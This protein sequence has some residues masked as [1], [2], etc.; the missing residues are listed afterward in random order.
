MKN[1]LLGILI[2]SPL[3]LMACQQKEAVPDGWKKGLYQHSQEWINDEKKDE[4][5]PNQVGNYL[6]IMPPMSKSALIKQVKADMAF[7]K[8]GAFT[9]KTGKKLKVKSFYIA[10]KLTSFWQYY[11]Y[12]NWIHQYHP[13]SDDEDQDT[14]NGLYPAEIKYHQAQNYCAWLAKET[15]LPFALPTFKQWLYAATSRGT[16]W[17]Y[18]TNNGKLELG[19]NYPKGNSGISIPVT[20][21]PI[22]SLGI[23]QMMGNGYQWTKTMVTH[24]N[25][26]E[27]NVYMSPDNDF[28]NPVVMGRDYGDDTKTIKRI[29]LTSEYTRFVSS[30]LDKYSEPTAF[31]CVIN[32]DQPI[33]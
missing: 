1:P 5:Y 16:N 6:Y 25:Q 4:V 18:P 10:K 22:N 32:T 31:R 14:D 13:N 9:L 20:G 17:A 7:I 15:K 26:V 19:I 12:L 33:T 23:H 3:L 11:S 30:K 8:G 28:G 24:Q 2:L 21:L 29:N 27:Y